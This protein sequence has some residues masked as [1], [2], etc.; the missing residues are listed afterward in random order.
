[1]KKIYSFIFL[2]CSFSIALGATHDAGRLSGGLKSG[3]TGSE[4]V[5][6]VSNISDHI[7]GGCSFVSKPA[8]TINRGLSLYECSNSW[9]A[10][11]NSNFSGNNTA[12]VPG[13]GFVIHALS[14]IH[15]GS[16]LPV[17]SEACSSYG[18][19]LFELHG[20]V[21]SSSALGKCTSDHTFINAKILKYV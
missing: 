16:S 14:A 21:L 9:I 2:I 13:T 11:N 20:S 6:I 19:L 15:A 4:E 8:Q 12:R 5:V 10:T 17:L 3:R 18:F 1:M 7:R